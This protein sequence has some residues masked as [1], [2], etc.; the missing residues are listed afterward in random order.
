ML[1]IKEYSTGCLDLEKGK[2]YERK[3]NLEF[4]C[5][6]FRNDY[7]LCN[8]CITIVYKINAACLRL[9]FFLNSMTRLVISAIR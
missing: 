7:I 5:Y 4:H 3:K 6:I 8:V 9:Q 1:A 2:K